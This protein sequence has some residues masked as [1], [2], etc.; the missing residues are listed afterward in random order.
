[1]NEVCVSLMD[2]MRLKAANSV[3]VMLLASPQS[4]NMLVTKAKGTR[5]F[6]SIV[7]I[8]KSRIR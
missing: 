3:S 8:I 4:K 2:M 5:Y 6:L 7:L 1:M